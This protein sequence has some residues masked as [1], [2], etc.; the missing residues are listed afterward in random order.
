MLVPVNPVWPYAS[1]LKDWPTGEPDGSC[2][3]QARPRRSARPSVWPAV[4]RA[5]VSGLEQSSPATGQGP[6]KEFHVGERGEQPRVAT[7]PAEH[8]RVL[9]V[10]LTCHQV[11]AP[12]TLLGGHRPL[13]V[14]GA[15]VEEG[16]VI[17]RGVHTNRSTNSAR[18]AAGG[19]LRDQPQQDEAL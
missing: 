10:H 3:C 13:A 6:A 7:D 11:T 12:G 8:H 5:K 16:A 9:V 19:G 15:R 1:G 17:P 2:P 4:M 18:G 14:L